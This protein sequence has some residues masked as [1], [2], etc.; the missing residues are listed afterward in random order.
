MTIY[1]HSCG[2]HHI[3]IGWHGFLQE[4]ILIESYLH[5]LPFSTF[6]GCNAWGSA[7][8]TP[9]LE[10]ANCKVLANHEF[11]PLMHSETVQEVVTWPLFPCYGKSIPFPLLGKVEGSRTWARNKS[12]SSLG[13]KIPLHGLH[14]C[15][16]FFR[17]ALGYTA[18]PGHVLSTLLL[19]G[20]C[21]K[22]PWDV[23][24]IRFKAPWGVTERCCPHFGRNEDKS[25]SE[26]TEKPLDL[27][28]TCDLQKPK[29][30]GLILTSK[31]LLSPAK[32]NQVTEQ[33]WGWWLHCG[34]RICSVWDPKTSL[35]SQV[36]GFYKLGLPPKGQLQSLPITCLLRVAAQ[37]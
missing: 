2:S 37:C 30:D 3:F 11:V 25:L 22:A 34:C 33:H 9:K 5:F 23:W 1:N 19:P 28:R 24:K 27:N 6:T 10:E 14:A 16:S 7:H 26:A 8:C 35:P 4:I 32:V 20:A 17:A 29:I 36:Q 31:S 13:S 18:S 15:P 12:R 21:F